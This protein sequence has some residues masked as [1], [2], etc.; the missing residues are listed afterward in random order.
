MPLSSPHAAWKVAPPPL[1]WRMLQPAIGFVR[2]EGDR[3]IGILYG[4]DLN[5]EGGSSARVP[6]RPVASA[7]STSRSLCRIRLSLAISMP[8]LTAQYGVIAVSS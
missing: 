3:G 4:A 5:G 6:R 2:G 1:E 8:A 7:I